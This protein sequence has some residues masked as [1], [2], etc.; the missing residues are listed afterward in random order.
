MAPA[1]LGRGRHRLL[2]E[3]DEPPRGRERLGLALA[4]HGSGD[5]AGEPLLAELAQD[6]LE[7]GC[8]VGVEDLRRGDAGGLVH[9]HVERCVLAVGEASVGLVE[10][11]GRD[12]EVVEAGVDVGDAGLGERPR[13]LVVDGVD[14]GRATGEAVEPLGGEREGLLVTVDA[15]EVRLRA[16]LEDGLR[17][18]THAQGAV[19]VDRAAL[20]QR[21]CE[22][23]RRCGREAPECA[24]RRPFLVSSSR[25]S[26][27]GP[28]AGGSGA[29]AVLRGR[30][31]SCGWT[32]V[33]VLLCWTL[34]SGL[35]PL[36]G[37]RPGT[38]EVVPGCGAAGDL[39]AGAVG[40][41]A[42]RFVTAGRG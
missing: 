6:A 26:C 22:E 3:L 11:Q 19:E 24:G 23:A 34:R 27:S 9:P 2:E 25:C 38:G 20:G 13:H 28:A 37:M 39:A 33:P 40:S 8:G 29:R 18:A 42:R 12:A 32:G 15:D 16:G 36:R 4:D 7:V 10:L 5:L 17:V 31:W 35:H 14:E 1:L 41:G 21:R 30:C